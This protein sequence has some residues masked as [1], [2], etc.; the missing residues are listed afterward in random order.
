MPFRTL[1]PQVEF[2]WNTIPFVDR[3]ASAAR[4]TCIPVSVSLVRVE[5]LSCG[6]QMRVAR[7]LVSTVLLF[8]WATATLWASMALM[9]RAP[10]EEWI[11]H[12]A[13]L[14]FGLFG[15]ATMFLCFQRKSVIAFGVYVIAF[16]ILLVWWTSIVP[17][18]QGNWSRDVARQTTGVFDGDEVTLTDVRDF[19]WESNDRYTERWITRT[20]DLDDLETVDMFLSYWGG[21]QMAHFI[22]S[23][24][25]ADGQYLAWSIEVR[26]EIGGVYSPVADFFK[27][28]TLVILAATER[29]V[30][31]LR[32]NVREEDV[33]LYRL[34]TS[35]KAAK[36]L[37]RQYVRDANELAQRPAW[38]NS[39]TTNCTTV[40]FRMM[41]ALGRGPD[42]D[43]RMIANG[44]LPEY[45][46]EKGYL[47]RTVPFDELQ[48]Q[49]RI[50]PTVKSAGLDGRFSEM[51]RVGV[52]R[53]ID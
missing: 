37:F 10:G 29:D 27:E 45:A 8:I 4:Y 36:D 41:E 30:V 42:F 9:Y 49:A 15:F 11:G 7:T 2:Q 5:K 26:R 1:E 18:D 40:V 47:S 50:A 52:P 3:F 46:Y 20:Y 12:A 23:F 28:H 14:S 51:I 16:C 43:W 6:H 48:R 19:S 21:P 25:F 17:P 31:G 13:A 24:G 35:G 33:Q 32:S 53:P 34:S 39:I 22:L 44:Y 38:Y